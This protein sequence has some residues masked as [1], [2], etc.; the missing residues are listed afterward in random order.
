MEINEITEAYIEIMFKYFESLKQSAVC[1]KT[2]ELSKVLYI[3]INTL[4]RVFYYTLLKTQN[5]EKTIFYSQKS[6][7]FYLEYVEQFYSTEIMNEIDYQEATLLIYKSTLFNL[8]N[9]DNEFVTQLIGN[10]MTTIVTEN[11]KYNLKIIFK[12]INILCYWN[13]ET[14]TYIQQLEL[15]KKNIKK[16]LKSFTINEIHNYVTIIENIQLNITNISYENYILLLKEILDKIEK[17]KIEDINT[18]ILEKFYIE[19]EDLHKKK[20]NIKDMVKWLF[21]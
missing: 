10:D 21:V 20:G 16:I 14:I 8:Y 13:N 9:E 3:G 17:C 18:I 5:L 15:L 12:L 1:K 2:S 4:N 6:Y 11:I 19:K 7:I